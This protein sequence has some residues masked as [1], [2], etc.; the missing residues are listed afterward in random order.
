MLTI[1]TL[2]VNVRKIS[3]CEILRTFTYKVS[4]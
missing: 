4:S 1:D 2:Y 3:E